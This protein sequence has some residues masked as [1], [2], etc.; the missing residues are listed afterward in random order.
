MLRGRAASPI[1]PGLIIREFL[2]SNGSASI[3]ELHR[4]YKQLVK[5]VNQARPRG[6]ELKPMVYTSFA[7]YLRNCARLG[8]VEVADE[9]LLPIEG[10]STHGLLFIEGSGSK[11]KIVNSGQRR[12][13]L[14]PN[15]GAM[16]YWENPAK[17]VSGR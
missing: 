7:C 6:K 11:A 15:F 4:Y 5:E 3:S 17:Y 13:Q 14:G 9:P 2:G 1:R 10:K 8:L 16:E 12:Y